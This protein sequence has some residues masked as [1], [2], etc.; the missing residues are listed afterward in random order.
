MK[1]IYQHFKAS[2]QEFVDQVLDD[3]WRVENTHAPLLSPFLNPRE[4]Y[5][6]KSIVA[7]RD[8]IEQSAFGGLDEAENK[9]VLIYPYYLESPAPE[10]F[11]VALMAIDYPKKFTKLSHGQIMGSI[12]GAGLVKNRL[13]DIITDGEDW[14]FFIDKTLVDYVIQ[15]VTKIGRASVTLKERPLTEVL[16]PEQTGSSQEIVVSSLRLDL[17]IAR[18]F[19]L[20]RQLAQE[21]IKK[22]RV[23]INWAEETNP[24]AVVE[25]ADIISVRKK[26]RIR[27]GSVKGRTRK[28]N[29]VLKIKKFDRNQTGQ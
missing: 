10:A 6:I 19:H 21:F 17:I 12:L 4:R 15:Q 26:G 16:T 13:G 28:D 1:Q 22:E 7:G 27:V 20:S 8:E 23:K 29:C 5:I 18:T 3:V 11:E 14:Q 25:A 9:R 2:E 24:A